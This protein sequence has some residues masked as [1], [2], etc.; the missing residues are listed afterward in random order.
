MRLLMIMAPTEC[1]EDLQDL[2]HRHDVHAYTELPNLP[3]RGKSG[4]HLGTR[5]FPGTSSIFLTIVDSDTADRI[6][7]SIR[8]YCDRPV[9]CDKVRVFSIP[10]EQLV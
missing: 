5:A 7:K 1:L 2:V 6:A 4:G 10:A 8:D 9:N 3:G